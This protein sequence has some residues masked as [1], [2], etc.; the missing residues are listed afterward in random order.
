[1]T[2]LAVLSVAAVCASFVWYERRLVSRLALQRC[3]LRRQRRAWDRWDD[4]CMSTDRP[5]RRLAGALETAIFA[6]DSAFAY[7][8]R[9]EPGMARGESPFQFRRSR[10]DASVRRYDR[11]VDTVTTEAGRW[12]EAVGGCEDDPQTA[13]SI[14][15][16]VEVLGTHRAPADATAHPA[17]DMARIDV[18]VD[19]LENALANLRRARVAPR[20]AH[21]FR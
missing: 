4:L 9:L 20:S 17:D 14:G 15:R 3:A 10:I 6:G 21:P 8:D 11:A 16:L 2:F 1:V 13:A 18:T 7:R 12:L 5:T 19:A